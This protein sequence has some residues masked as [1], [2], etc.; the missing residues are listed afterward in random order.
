MAYL[1][2]QYKTIAIISIILGVV[3]MAAINVLTGV[4]FLIGAAMLGPVRIH[5]HVCVGSTPT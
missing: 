4:A 5:R 2:R 3:I 1:A